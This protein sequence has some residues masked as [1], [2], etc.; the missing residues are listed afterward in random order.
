MRYLSTIFFPISEDYP[1][2][3]RWS[4]DDHWSILGQEGTE[5]DTWS[6]ASQVHPAID[7]HAGPA[8]DP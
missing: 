3:P 5:A 4:M 2:M 7:F 1:S 6:S 8:L